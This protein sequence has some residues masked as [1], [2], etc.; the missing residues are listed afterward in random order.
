MKRFIGLFVLS[1]FFGA[2]GCATK[3]SA[4]PADNTKIPAIISELA[5]ARTQGDQVAVVRAMKALRPFEADAVAFETIVW[6]RAAQARYDEAGR[7]IDRLAKFTE[8]DHMTIYRRG[9]VGADREYIDE[10]YNAWL[11]AAEETG[12]LPNYGVYRRIQAMTAREHFLLSLLRVG[13]FNS[14]AIGESVYKE[15]DEIYEVMHGEEWPWIGGL[16]LKAYRL[17]YGDQNQK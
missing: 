1:V 15:F 5:V 10:A 13:K 16:E 6:C 17:K 11:K 7:E 2:T 14:L 12:H 9:G 8:R 4:P 3:P